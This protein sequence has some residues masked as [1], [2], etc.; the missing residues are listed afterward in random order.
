MLNR[1][2]LR[3]LSVAVAGAIGLALLPASP[4]A[5]HVPGDNGYSWTCNGGDGNAGVLGT[6][7]LRRTNSDTLLA[8]VTQWCQVEM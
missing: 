2:G 8:S 6:V 7:Q 1:V 4:A 3:A 5:A